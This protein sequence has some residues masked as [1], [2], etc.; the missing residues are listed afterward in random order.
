MI[1]LLKPFFPRTFTSHMSS[2]FSNQFPFCPTFPT[3]PRSA[4][5]SFP[6]LRFISPFSFFHQKPISPQS[7]SSAL[8]CLLLPFLTLHLTLLSSST[9]FSSLPQSPLPPTSASFSVHSSSSSPTI[10]SHASLPALSTFPSTV[11]GETASTTVTGTLRFWPSVRTNK[12]LRLMEGS[13]LH[14]V[15]S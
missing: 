1:L 10:R 6:L 8:P 11:V 5:S 12:V 9:I 2:P 7:D 3:F 4:S 13:P 15:A 14:H